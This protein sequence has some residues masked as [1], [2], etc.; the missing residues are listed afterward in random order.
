MVRQ[1]NNEDSKK[2]IEGHKVGVVD[3]RSET[4]CYRGTSNDIVCSDVL[5]ACPKAQ[6]D[7]TY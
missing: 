7:H 2:G 4:G 3:E 1:I 6:N 5:D